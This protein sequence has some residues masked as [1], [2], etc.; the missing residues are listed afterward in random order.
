M[1]LDAE[2][3]RILKESFVANGI[4]EAEVANGDTWVFP[5]NGGKMTKMYLQQWSGTP[6]DDAILMVYN[7]IHFGGAMPLRMCRKV[8]SQKA[9]RSG[10]R[11][12][13]PSARFI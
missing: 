3:E 5:G 2:A 9:Q 1:I 11:T 7:G 8:K 6:D 13:P 4:S 10:R 12:T